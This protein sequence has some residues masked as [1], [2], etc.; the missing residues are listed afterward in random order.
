MLFSC[1]SIAHSNCPKRRDLDAP[2]FKESHRPIVTAKRV[3]HTLRCELCGTEIMVAETNG[4]TN[5][6]TP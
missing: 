5:A 2:S 3:I 4:K 6:R 1:E